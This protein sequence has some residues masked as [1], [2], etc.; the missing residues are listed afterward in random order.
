VLLQ[1][2]LHPC[3]RRAGW[4]VDVIAMIQPLLPL[5]L[6]AHTF[7]LPQALLP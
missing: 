7:G 6:T 4:C 1:L 5:L 2:L 3:L